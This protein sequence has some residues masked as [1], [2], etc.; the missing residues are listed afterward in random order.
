MITDSRSS[1]EAIS[2]MFLASWIH[3]EVAVN[4]IIVYPA[5]RSTI[6]MNLFVTP[7]MKSSS[8]VQSN[9]QPGPGELM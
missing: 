3:L 6:R 8:H 1:P 9:L 5:E 4:G 7:R 2:R